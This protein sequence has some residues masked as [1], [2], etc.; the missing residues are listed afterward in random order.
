MVDGKSNAHATAAR[1]RACR[2]VAVADTFSTLAPF[3]GG[4]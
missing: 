2:Y 4:N 1:V 3:A